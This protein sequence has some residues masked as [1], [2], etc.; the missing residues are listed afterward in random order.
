MIASNKSLESKVANLT[1]SNEKAIKD[2]KKSERELKSIQEKDNAIVATNTTLQT[3]LNSLKS[4]Y[5][6]LLEEHHN[7]QAKEKEFNITY[8]DLKKNY[9]S[10]HSSLFKVNEERRKLFEDA[11]RSERMLRNYEKELEELK[12]VYELEKLNYGME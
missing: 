8:S 10:C 2:C 11:C 4:T 5:D 9:E 6:K 3:D 7:L 1:T 12:K